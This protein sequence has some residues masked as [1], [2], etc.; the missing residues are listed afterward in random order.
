M[1]DI[2]E[3]CGGSLIPWKNCFDQNSFF[4]IKQCFN[5]TSPLC[6]DLVYLWCCIEFSYTHKHCQLRYP[7]TELGGKKPYYGRCKFAETPHYKGACV[8]IIIC[9]LSILWIS[10]KLR[11]T[12]QRHCASYFSFIAAIHGGLTCLDVHVHHVTLWG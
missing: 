5:I 12:C 4:F 1:W 9:S 3:K 2:P 7:K 10:F 6:L 11:A 8:F